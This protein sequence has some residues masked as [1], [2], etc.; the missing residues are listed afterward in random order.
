MAP[1]R[2]ASMSWRAAST[3]TACIASRVRSSKL[4]LRQS[5]VERPTPGLSKSMNAYPRLTS[6]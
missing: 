4:C 6:L 3:R 1:M 2:V 5:P